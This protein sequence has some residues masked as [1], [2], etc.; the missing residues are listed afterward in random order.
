MAWAILSI[1]SAAFGSVAN[2]TDKWIYS[3]WLRTPLLSLQM[4]GFLSLAVGI[5]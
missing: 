2:V 1:L 3:R 4:E 5:V